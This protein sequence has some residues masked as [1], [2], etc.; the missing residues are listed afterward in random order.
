[1][2][3]TSIVVLSIAFAAIAFQPGTVNAQTK[4]RGLDADIETTYDLPGG[5]QVTTHGHYYRSQTGLL[6]E[7]SPLGAIITDTKQRVITLLNTE[8]KEARVIRITGEIEPP[9]RK[10]TDAAPASE[11][12]ESTVEG[13]AVMK[14]RTTGARGETQELWTA[15]ELGL[16]VMSKIE[17]QGYATTR[18][19][20]NITVREPN[21]SV[22]RVPADYTV[23]EQ[24]LPGALSAVPMR[25]PVWPPAIPMPLKQDSPINR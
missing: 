11:L 12:K 6:R 1:M 3:K 25:P 16:V 9:P 5:Q 20:R 7:E 10:S 23:T 2:L 22:F 18:V 14:A 8:M 19:L 13:H 21:P 4:P 24:S 15:T 17:S